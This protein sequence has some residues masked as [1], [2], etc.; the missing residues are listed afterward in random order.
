MTAPLTERKWLR[1]KEAAAFLGISL[2]TLYNWRRKGIVRFHRLGPRVVAVRREDL[3]NVGQSEPPKPEGVLTS[4]TVRRLVE[5]NE[6]MRR[7]Y[8]ILPSSTPIIREE[9]DRHNV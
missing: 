5:L 6:R 1:P 3:Q 9:R 7:K 4:E 8:G 2:S